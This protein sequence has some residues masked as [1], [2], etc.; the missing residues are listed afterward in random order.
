M[1]LVMR[2]TTPAPWRI[3]PLPLIVHSSP[4]SLVAALETQSQPHAAVDALL[5][6][7]LEQ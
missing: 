1:T 3:P 2:D 5:T 7:T 6:A 4:L